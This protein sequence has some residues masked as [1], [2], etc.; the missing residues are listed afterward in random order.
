MK[1][2]ALIKLRGV[3]RVAKPK[4][5]KPA[6]PRLRSGGQMNEDALAFAIS[7]G[8]PDTKSAVIGLTNAGFPSGEIIKALGGT[9]SRQAISH[10]QKSAGVIPNGYPKTRKPR[11]PKGKV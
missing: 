8:Y 1:V 6:T 7:L 3:K 10:H 9:I 4:V 2:E 5:E 11:T